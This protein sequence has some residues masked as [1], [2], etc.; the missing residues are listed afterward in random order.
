MSKFTKGNFNP[1]HIDPDVA[2]AGWFPSSMLHGLATYGVIGRA[3]LSTLGDNDPSRGRRM[4]VR[5]SRSD[6]PGETIC[7]DL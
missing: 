3:L 1:F 2:Q 7:T 4:D 5:F 6:E